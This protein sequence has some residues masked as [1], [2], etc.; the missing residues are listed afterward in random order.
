MRLR[1]F[2]LLILVLILVAAAALLLLGNSGI[3][4]LAGF[5]ASPLNRLWS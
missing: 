2:I 3:G 4:P 5:L 1:T